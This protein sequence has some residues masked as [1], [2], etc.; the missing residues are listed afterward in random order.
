MNKI[1]IKLISV[2]L[3]L[4]FSVTVVFAASYAWLVLSQSPAV[5]GIQVAIGGGNTILIAPNIR[6]VALDGTAY[7]YPG[8][9]S[10][11]M[12][13]SQQDAYAYLQSL[14]KL[15][16]VSTV[17]GVDWIL[18]TYYSNADRLVQEGRVPRGTIKEI[19][20]FAVDRELSYANIPVQE[21]EEI[22]GGHY[23]YLD[24]WVVSP[25]GD[26]K[27]RV[28]TGVEDLDGGSF[29][30]SLLD[31]EED[32]AGWS[33]REDQNDIAAA[34]RVGFLANDLLVIDESMQRY[35]NSRY[36]DGRFGRLKGFYQEPNTGTIYSDHNRFTI[37]EPN[38]DY[39]PT[40]A[41]IDGC[42]VETKPLG[43]V[44]GQI[45]EL[46]T[47]ERLT[48]QKK[49]TWALAEGYTDVTAIEQV[50][51]T[52]VYGYSADNMDADELTNRFYRDYLQGYI[53]PYVEKGGFI[54][55]TSNLYTMLSANDGVVPA[56]LLQD[57]N[58][59]ATNDVCIIELE[60]N[61]PQRIRM[62][63]WLEGQDADCINSVD[64]SRFAVNI[65]LASG[66][67]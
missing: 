17:N 20:D 43:L 46:R 4:V 18:P 16:P 59:G 66:D 26:Y 36:Y 37:Y 63:I 67:E 13:F 33:L 41:S 39:H 61:I 8:F 6:E 40:D 29:V 51:Q 23:V 64:A 31:P 32:A 12:N 5:T 22:N 42:Y 27:L 34:V 60:R 1:Y 3:A 53:S 28:S 56:A 30:I 52:A 24:F 48:V 58:Y 49:T 44:D 65:E 25:G 10:D 55:W 11:K 50:F 9:F 62:F 57:Q 54:Q 19:S 14:G 45:T 7:N 38:A 35:T 21:M 2:V 15:T 47:Q